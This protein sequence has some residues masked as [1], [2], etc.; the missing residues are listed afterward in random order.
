M[1]KDIK[2]PLLLAAVIIAAMFDFSL[3]QEAN[4]LLFIMAGAIPLA[5]IWLTFRVL[6]AN[7]VPQVREFSDED[8]GTW[9][10]K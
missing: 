2:F 4:V 8:S 3:T 6:K 5:V 1:L 7:T 10:E 9:Y